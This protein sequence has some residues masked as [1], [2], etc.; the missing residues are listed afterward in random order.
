ML[1]LRT[2]T[3]SCLLRLP[4]SL[5]S[6]SY[7]MLLHPI[8]PLTCAIVS[9]ALLQPSGGM[10]VSEF[11]RAYMSDVVLVERDGR[12]EKHCV[13]RCKEEDQRLLDGD[14]DFSDDGA[15]EYYHD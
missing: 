5:S 7:Y 10:K 12:G 15:F 13:R 11:A 1:W 9:F 8:H 3:C 4:C 2:Q 14:S 6:G